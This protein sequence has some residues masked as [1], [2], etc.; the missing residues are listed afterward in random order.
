MDVEAFVGDLA[1]SG[2]CG[3]AKFVF[4]K[5][6]VHQVVESLAIP[7]EAVAVESH[8]AALSLLHVAVEQ[9]L[10]G[11]VV[12]CF[13]KGGKRRVSFVRT[14]SGKMD[15]TGFD[16]ERELAS[17]VKDT[18]AVCYERQGCLFFQE[19]PKRRRRRWTVKRQE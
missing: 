1:R 6:E 19:K 2:F 10:T 4:E 17:C 7:R 14:H 12:L 3:A 8:E 15:G 13:L 11:Y 16:L 9:H 18:Q 5:G